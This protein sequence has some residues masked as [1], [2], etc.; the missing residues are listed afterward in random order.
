[1]EARDVKNKDSYLRMMY[2]AL[3]HFE[4]QTQWIVARREKEEH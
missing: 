4:G 2:N 3:K 1:M